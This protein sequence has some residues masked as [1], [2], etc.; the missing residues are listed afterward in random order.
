LHY[1]SSVN[2]KDIKAEVKMHYFHAVYSS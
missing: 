1:D 2:K